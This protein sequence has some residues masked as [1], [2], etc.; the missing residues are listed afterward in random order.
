MIYEDKWQ[1]LKAAAKNIRQKN[2]SDLFCE[3]PRRVDNFSMKVDQIYWDYSKNYLTKEILS[4]LIS[5]AKSVDLQGAIDRLMKGKE[6]NPSEKR[7][8]LHTALRLKKGTRLLIQDKD[9]MPTIFAQREKM[10]QMVHQLQQQEWFGATGIPITD[11]VNLGIGGSDLGPKMAVQA[12]KHYQQSSLNVHFVS[13]VDPDAITSLLQKLNP[14]ST[15]FILSSKSFTTIETLTNA[16]VAKEWLKSH[17]K[18]ENLQNHF[19]AVTTKPEKA[20]AFGI[21]E[22]N[23]L[24]FEEWVGGRYSVWSTIGLPLALSIGMAHFEQF[25]QGASLMDEHFAKTPL[26]ENMPVLLA[27]IGIWYING[28]DA[29]TLAILPYAHGLRRLPDYLQQLDMESNGKGVCLD[30]QPSY[31]ATA[32]IVW[33]QAGTNGQHAFY[34]LLHQGTHFVPIDFIVAAKTDTSL[35]AQHQQFL[36]HC[37]GQAAAL[38]QGNQHQT[39]SCAHERMPGNKPSNLFLL[40]QINPRALGQLLAL[41]EHK[42]YV[43]GIIWQINSFDQPGVEL[44]KKL[45]NK[46][47]MSLQSGKI[48]PETDPSTSVLIQ[49][50]RAL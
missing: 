43:Q 21:D 20:Q 12:L 23:I 46:L 38:M 22:N 5:L 36:A 25:L 17:L 11:V 39:I 14:A 42:I 33:G 29:P 41:Y 35:H 6:V 28:W 27:L 31:Y 48:D 2:L 47:M 44:G 13:N 24:T 1:A 32:P 45:A 30:G 9:V 7:P 19:I 16:M 18:T 26:E 50:I 10:S 8:A 4:E 15:L 3:D 37:L 40:D 49:K 34:Q